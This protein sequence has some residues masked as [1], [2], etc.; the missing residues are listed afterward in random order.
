MSRITYDTKV[1]TVS[2]PSAE[3]NKIT[4]SNMNE[5]KT[6]VNVAYDLIEAITGQP[7]ATEIRDELQ[8]LTG[9]NRLSATAVKD[10]PLYD[11]DGDNFYVESSEVRI[12][13][14]NIAQDTTGGITLTFKRNTMY[15][16]PAIPLSGAIAESFTD[17][18]IGAEAILWY[19]DSSLPL[20]SD[21]KY[22]PIL[23][24]YAPNVLNQV[25]LRYFSD[26]YITY[27]VF[28]EI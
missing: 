25:I 12:K 15:G 26:T 5:I 13:G 7:T 22:K 2:N 9:V 28:Q 3:I 27:Q 20:D 18:N 14:G 24:T 8:T 23:G 1:D 17:A 19:D 11:L 6:S 10:I 21:S 16:T 4:A